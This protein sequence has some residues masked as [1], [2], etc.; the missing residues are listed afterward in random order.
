LDGNV[1]KVADRC[2]ARVARDAILILARRSSRRA[3]GKR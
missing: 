1:G 3:V 2:T